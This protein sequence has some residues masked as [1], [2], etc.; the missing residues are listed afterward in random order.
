MVVQS[1]KKSLSVAVIDEFYTFDLIRD[2]CKKSA[3][4]L[5]LT[6]NFKFF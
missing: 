6:L 3:A 1:G 5:T 2:T 4:K